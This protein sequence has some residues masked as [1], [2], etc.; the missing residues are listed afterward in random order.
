MVLDFKNQTYILD[1]SRPQTLPE[2]FLP[3]EHLIFEKFTQWH[4]N[5][6]KLHSIVLGSMSYEI[7]K[8]YERYETSDR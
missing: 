7:Q 1:K 8:Q 6:W 5:N 3:G 4:E 2:G